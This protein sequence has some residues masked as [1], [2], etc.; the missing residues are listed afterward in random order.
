MTKQF[1]FTKATIDVLPFPEKGKR[2]YYKDEKE[3]GLIIDVRPSGSKSF[4]LYKKINGKPERVFIGQ[5]PD[6]KVPQARK[7]CEILKGEIAKGK[8]P[9]DEKRKV[10]QEITFGDFFQEYMERYSRPHKKSW[11]YDEREVSKFLS[12]WLK[13]KLSSIK[14]HE[15]K[16]LHD[17]IGS[18]N[19]IYQGNRI[20]ERI[21]G[22]YSKAI[23][24]GWEGENPATGIKK[25]REKSRDRF[26]QPNELPFLFNALEIEENETARDFIKMSLMTGAR[27]SNVLAMRWDQINWDHK[28]WR[29]PETKNGEPITL[30]LIPQAM[31][32]LERRKEKSNSSWVFEGK[33]KK[34]H[35]A[36]PKK[37]WNRVRQRA[38]LALWKLD[39]KL[40][41]FIDDVKYRLKNQDNYGFTILRLF[42][43]ITKEAEKQRIELPQGLLDVRL[44][45]LRRT[46]GSYQAITGASLPVIG[47]TLGHKSATATA[48]YARLHDDPVRDSME[49]A[50]GAMFGYMESN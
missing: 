2:A 15:V 7:N 35:L 31:E 36:D 14:K 48:V 34:G 49:K 24:W 29:I 38:T 4:Y 44:H 18:K 30:P 43:T 16:K 10:R 19:G 40:E 46:F 39:P 22:I 25:F 11:K 21:R 1:N 23:E 17:E 12:H 26:I 3:S 9:Q 27:K 41:D 33:G 13:R 42:N 6:M 50:A 20:L 32:L 37:S 5:H 47:K 28:K 8:N 45:D